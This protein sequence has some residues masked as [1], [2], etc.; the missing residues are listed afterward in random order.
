MKKVKIQD[1][2]Y[3]A[4]IHGKCKGGKTGS[5]YDRFGRS[6][7]NTGAFDNTP[8][9]VYFAVPSVV[10]PIDRLEVL[11]EREFCDYLIPKIRNFRRLTE[12]INPKFTEITVDVI[13]DTIEACIKQEKLPIMRLKKEYVLTCQIDKEFVQKVRDDPKKY[14]EKIT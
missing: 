11:Y 6:Q 3:I 7:Y 4:N 5:I 12:F 9:Y 2:F 1:Q 8:S 13:R 14:L 10:F